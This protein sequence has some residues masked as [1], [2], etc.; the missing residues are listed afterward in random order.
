MKI[1]VKPAKRGQFV[2]NFVANNG[3]VTANNETYPTRGNAVRAAKDNIRRV[4]TMLGID[5]EIAFVTPR[6]G[7]YTYVYVLGA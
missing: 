6:T 2:W 3:R 5:G 4:A 7:D 1:I